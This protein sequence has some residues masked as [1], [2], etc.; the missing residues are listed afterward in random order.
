MIGYDVAGTGRR[1]AHRVRPW[2]AA[3]PRDV[4]A[5]GAAAVGHVPGHRAGP[6]RSRCP[7]RRALHAGR[8]PPTWS[9]PR[10]MRRRAD[11]RSSS[12]CRWVATWRSTWPSEAPSASGAWSWPGRPPSRPAR[13]RSRTGP[14]AGALDAFQGHGL[15]ALNRWFFRPRFAPAIAEPIVSGGFWA[16]GGAE[17][18]RCLAGHRF[19]PS[20]AAY[21]GPVLILNGSLDIPFRLGQGGFKSVANDVRSVRIAGRDPPVQ[22]RSAGRPSARPYAG[23]PKGWDLT[24]TADRGRGPS[25]TPRVYSRGPVHLHTSRSNARSKGRLPCRRLGHPLPARHEGAAQGDAPLV[26][27]PIIQYAVEE[28]VAAGIEQVIIVTSSQKRAIEDHFDLSYELE[29]LLEEKG[30]IEN[31]PA[32]P[33]DQRPRPDRLR[34]PEGAAGSRPRGPDGQGPHRPRAVRG[35]PAGRRRGRATGRASASSSTS[36]TR[37]TRRSSRSWRSPTRRP[38]GTA[39]S[40]PRPADDPL[41]HGRL[42]RVT[43][44]V[45]KPDPADAPS[46]LAIIGRYVLT[47]KIFDKLEQTQ[48]GARAAR[49]S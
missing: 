49:S 17:A 37:P 45:E 31:A 36:T 21:R 19:K 48:R 12:A 29:H 42:H 8:G 7:G 40:A 14:L 25:T 18:L 10:S 13:W 26:D 1:R 4:A 35:H 28:A 22:P 2:H 32:G 20:L 15:D 3:D 33:P 38:R 27:K 5:P 16:P 43:S 44:L 23:S 9:R 24:A 34:A 47:P 46:N 41:D 30:D 39:S 6:A 11:R